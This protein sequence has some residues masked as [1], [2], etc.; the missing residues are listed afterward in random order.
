MPI[1]P[2]RGDRAGRRGRARLNAIAVLLALK[3][4]N[5]IVVDISPEKREDAR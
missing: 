4:Q 2:H 1:P 5:I 3:H